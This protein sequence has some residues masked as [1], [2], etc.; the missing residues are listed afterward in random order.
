M[1]YAIDRIENNI[2]ICQNLETRK[3]IEISLNCLPTNI[4]ND[5]MYP[6]KKG[7]LL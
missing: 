1:K 2:A 5:K 7:S 3:E 4:K 6:K